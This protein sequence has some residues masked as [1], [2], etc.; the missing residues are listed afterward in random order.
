M[1]FM[2]LLQLRSAETN[3]DSIT[4]A[5][6]TQLCIYIRFRQ[7]NHAEATK[8][9]MDECPEWKDRLSKDFDEDEKKLRQLRELQG[10]PWPLDS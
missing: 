2:I 8:L 6:A 4:R 1:T 9:I 5:R 7:E 10:I 3:A